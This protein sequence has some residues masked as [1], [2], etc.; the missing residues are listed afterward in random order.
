MGAIERILREASEPFIGKQND[1]KNRNAMRTAIK[2]GLES[3]KGTLIED[4][5]FKFQPTS[6]STNKLGIIDIDYVI[7][8]IYEIR[9]VRHSIRV[10]DTIE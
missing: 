4:Y 3:I 2:A 7:I 6:S 1:P 9:Q 10:G 5:S 8:P